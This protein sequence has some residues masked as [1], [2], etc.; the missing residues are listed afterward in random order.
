MQILITRAP[1]NVPG[2]ALYLTSSSQ[3]RGFMAA[4]PIFTA[5]QKRESGGHSSV[6]PVLTSSGNFLAG[7]TTRIAVGFALNPFSVL[8]ARYEVRTLSARSPPQAIYDA[9]ISLFLL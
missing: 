5:A 3:V 7:A 4:S 1:S 9:C 6:L 2:I 8:K